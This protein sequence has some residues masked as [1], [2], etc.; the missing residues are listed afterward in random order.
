LDCAWRS[1]S[2][3]EGENAC[4]FKAKAVQQQLPLQLYVGYTALQRGS[5][6]RVAVNANEKSQL[7]GGGC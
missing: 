6:A 3:G 2:I 1:R 7:A 5:L 4:R